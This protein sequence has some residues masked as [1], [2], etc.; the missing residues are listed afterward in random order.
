MDIEM[1]SG[2]SRS[3]AHRG[4]IERVKASA[5]TSVACGTPGLY[6]ARHPPA[7]RFRPKL[8]DPKM[9]IE[10]MVVAAR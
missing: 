1:L 8:N 5:S 4:G 9:K 3:G 6:P 7:R 2:R 10:I